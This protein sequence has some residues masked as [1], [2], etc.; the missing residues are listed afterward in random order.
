[1]SKHLPIILLSAVLVTATPVFA[2]DLKP[3][4]SPLIQE[5]ET[6][7]VQPK[8]DK[9]VEDLRKDI[10][11]DAVDA[12]VETNHALILLENGKPNEAIAAIKTAIGKLAITLEREPGLGLKP[13]H[14]MKRIHDLQIDPAFIQP[15]TKIAREFL[16][17]GNLQGARQLIAPLVSEMTITITSIPL[18]SYPE[19]IKAVVPL[20]DDGKIDEAKATLRMLLSTLV[21]KDLTVP[22]PPLRA[23]ALLL[24]AETLTENESRTDMENKALTET[25]KE[26]RHQLNPSSWLLSP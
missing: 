20:I 17:D 10:I 8:I 14:V 9:Q 5:V 23:E 24:K 6:E 19:A 21:V 12:V 1:M 2:E 13:V 22:L 26:A 25:L 3:Q 16:K 11:S 7:S 4:D 15:K 18:G